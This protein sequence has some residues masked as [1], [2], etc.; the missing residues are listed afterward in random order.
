MNVEHRT[1][2]V[3]HRMKKPGQRR[4]RLVVFKDERRTSNVQHRMK[5]PG[6][7]RPR[8]RT[9][10][11]YFT[12]FQVMCLFLHL[13]TFTI[14][15]WTLDVQ[16]SMFIPF[17]IHSQ[18]DVGRWTLDVQCS[19]PS[20]SIH[21]STLDVGRWTFNVHPLPYPFTIRRWTFDVQCSFFPVDTGQ[22]QL[23]AYGTR[24]PPRR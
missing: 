6:Q 22:K 2:N 16:C 20:L 21:H 19:S 12:F 17:L 14:R 23:S 1:S 18:F 4:L 10:N 3:Q 8:Y 15:R 5:K 11:D 24:R 9:L 7:R 13:F